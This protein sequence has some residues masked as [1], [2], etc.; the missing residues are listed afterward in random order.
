LEESYGKNFLEIVFQ[1]KHEIVF[2]SHR[3]IQEIFPGR[4]NVLFID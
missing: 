3:R 2:K 4:Y 1:W